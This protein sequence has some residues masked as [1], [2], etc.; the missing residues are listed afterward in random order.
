M[1]KRRFL[2][3]RDE[4]GINGERGEGAMEEE[5]KKTKVVKSADKLRFF[6]LHANT[7][8]HLYVIPFIKILKY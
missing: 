5:T 2:D 4:R 7:Y 8:V 6:F 1:E 3:G